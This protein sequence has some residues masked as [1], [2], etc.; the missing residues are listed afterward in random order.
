[1]VARRSSWCKWGGGKW[2][3]AEGGEFNTT[4]QSTHSNAKYNDILFCR[5]RP[6]YHILRACKVF[7][8][9]WANNYNYNATINPFLVYKFNFYSGIHYVTTWLQNFLQK[10]MYLAFEIKSGKFFMLILIC[11]LI[12]VPFFCRCRWANCKQCPFDCS[13]FFFLQYSN[14]KSSVSSN[15]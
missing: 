6:S 9:P 7:T 5:E 15:V 13:Y 12:R 1:M 14:K 10:M 3:R 8:T 11:F 4:A 2:V